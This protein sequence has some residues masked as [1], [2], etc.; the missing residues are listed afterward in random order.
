M[1]VKQILGANVR[2]Y[3]ERLHLSQAE[4]SARA[5]L[6]IDYLNRIETGASFVTAAR[7]ENLCR[8]L[9]VSAAVLFYTEAQST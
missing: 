8:A 6:S 1:N 3:R 2:L 7:L 9:G 4:L 5:G